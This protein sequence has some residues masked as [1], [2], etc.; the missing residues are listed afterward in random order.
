[1]VAA[2]AMLGVSGCAADAPTG[3]TG[4]TGSVV[5]YHPDYPSYENLASLYEQADVVIEATIEPGTKVQNLTPSKVSESDPQLNPNAGMPSGQQQASEALVVTVF[6]AKANRVFKGDVKPGALVPVKQLGGDYQGVTYRETD[7]VALRSGT[8]YILFLALFP[9]S[10]ASLLN[11]DQAQYPLDAAGKPGP[12]SAE[13][14]TFTVADLER[15]S[16]GR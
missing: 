15:L 5:D 2:V 3:D 11:P 14:V 1:M 12:V 4:P 16:A 6:Q 7:A 13:A 8:G 9:D 10:P